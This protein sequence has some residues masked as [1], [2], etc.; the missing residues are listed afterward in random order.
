M[1][2]LLIAAAVLA[3][4]AAGGC[5]IPDDSDVTVVGSGPSSGVSIGDDG[6]PPR[7]YEREDATM[8][9]RVFARYYLQAAAGDPETALAR[10]KEFLAP[11]LAASFTA[12]SQDVRVVRLVKDPL[13][14]PGDPTASVTLT[15][16]T[17]GSLNA[18]GVLTP[19]A[20]PTAGPE[21]FKMTIDTISGRSGLFVKNAPPVMMI[22]DTALDAFYESRTVYWWNMENTGLVPDVRYMPKSVPAVQQPTTVLSWL[23]NGPAD[24]LKDAVHPLQPGTAA[25]ENVPAI[26]DDTL[27]ISLSA[28]A[29]PPND[30]GALDRLRRQLQ[31]SLRPL[32]YRTLV[33]TIGRQDPVRFVDAEYLSSNA[34]YRLVDKPERFVVYNGVIRRL[35]KSPRPDDPV[36]LL[37]PEANKGIAGAAMSASSTHTF[38]AVLT[39]PAGNQQ[40]RVGTAPIGKEGDVA[41]VRGLSGSLGRPDWASTPDGD[42]SKAFGLIT[43]GGRLYSFQGDGSPARRV[44]WQGSPGSVAMTAVSVAP[45]GRRVAVV[46][47]GRLY[48]TVLTLDGTDVA[49]NGAEQ[50]LPPTFGSVSAVAWTSESHLAVAGIRGDR[51]S[52]LDVS[53]DGMLALTASGLSDI[54]TSPVTHLTAYPANPVT[55]AEN[56]GTEVYEAAGGAWEVLS[57]AFPI[58]TGDLAGPPPS[59]QPNLRPVAPFFFG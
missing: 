10:V 58:N 1:R 13:W 47:G 55:R 46:A 16:K 43:M 30:S 24:W 26:T 23:A 31:W 20:D 28:Q 48:R 39:G 7:Q 5:G 11:E 35:S 44:D 6:V 18:N 51:Y 59:A 34:A 57:T 53:L 2:R 14:T 8:D 50:L 36:P 56:L 45:D 42:P 32:E 15:L 33:L 37:K 17:V 19:T 40:L 4:L 54:G 25:P 52:V 49:L 3:T 29:V 12:G 9:P 41:V 22:S 21:D 38:A 27:Q